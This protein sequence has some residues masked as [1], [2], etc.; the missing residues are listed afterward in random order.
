MSDE[1]KTRIFKAKKIITI[2]PD[3][4]TA[5][6]VA[7]ED[8][9]ISAVGDL[10]ELRSRFEDAEIDDTFAEKVLTP[11]LIDAHCHMQMEGTFWNFAWIGYFD[12]VSPDRK[13]IHGLRSVSAVLDRLKEV[14]GQ[15]DDPGEALVAWGFDPILLDDQDLT[16]VELDEVSTSRPVLVLN[17]SEHIVYANNAL[18]K[19]AGITSE[20][21]VEGVIKGENGSPNGILE[22]MQAMFLVMD[23]MPEIITDAASAQSIM[24][25][26]K[27]AQRAGC[28]TASE[29]AC[30][31]GAA[32]D[33]FKAQAA[34]PDFPVRV[35]ISPLARAILNHRSPEEAIAFLEDVRKDLPPKMMLGPAKWVVDGSI[36]GYT[37]DLMWPGYCGDHSNP[38][39][40]TP[41]D[42]LHDQIKPFHKAGF[43][44]AMHVNGDGATE[45]ALKAVEKLLDEAPRLDHRHRLEHCQV[46][47]H[48]Q[49]ERMANLGMCVNLFSNHIYYWGD[50]H[51]AKTVGPDK[52]LRMDATATA[53]DLGIHFSMHSDSPV[54]PIG[55]L[56]S[57]WCA[58]NRETLSGQV[59]GEHERISVEDALAAMTIGSAYLIHRDGELGSIEV[60]KFADFTVL[61]EDPLS[62]KPEELKDV[63]V[64]GTV[65]GGEVQKAA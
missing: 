9:R 18:L 23:F 64:W 30:F 11:G 45:I 32:F 35:A 17:A 7:V 31:M 29:L 36:Q 33:S 59:L 25:G 61:D 15:L 57:A 51:K 49:F 65:L 20:T 55:P 13:T 19:K 40:N 38:I 62:V 10:N 63:P 46:A 34:K 53:L 6:A 50:Q 22:E 14:E 52:V 47:S 56:F 26:A 54:T 12:R 58:V 2:N 60:G 4:P 27:L 44:V 3:Q 42:E 21:T 48:S 43:Q 41:L 5:E 37:A 24:N 8:G 28:T 39:I 16:T 1:T